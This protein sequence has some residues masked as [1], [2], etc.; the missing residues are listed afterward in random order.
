MRA[1]VVILAVG[2]L[3]M[4]SKAAMHW[5]ERGEGARDADIAWWTAVAFILATGA[6]LIGLLFAR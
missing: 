5:R 4:G 6:A 2:G 3:L 1:L